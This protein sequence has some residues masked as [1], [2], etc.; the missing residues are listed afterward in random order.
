MNPFKNK[1]IV[2]VETFIGQDNGY[3]WTTSRVTKGGATDS[4]L[5]PWGGDVSDARIK[6]GEL[7]KMVGVRLDGMWVDGPS[8]YSWSV[9][10]P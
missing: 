6:P 3:I 1:H 7:I 10:K 8:S 9:M 2:I 5:F 4:L